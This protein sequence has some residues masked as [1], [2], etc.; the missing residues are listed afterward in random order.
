MHLSLLEWE[1]IALGFV[2]L[3]VIL[4]S[5]FFCLCIGLCEMSAK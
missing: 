4:I 1:I 3:D 5:L 2:K